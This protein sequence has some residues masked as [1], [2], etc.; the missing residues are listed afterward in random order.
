MASTRPASPPM[1]GN[2]PATKRQRLGNAEASELPSNLTND[3]DLF[4][5]SGPIHDDTF[6]LQDGSC[7][8][9]IEDVLF[10]VRHL[11]HPVY[12]AACL[13]A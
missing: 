12:H 3:G 11:D 13:Y 8:I 10:N 5:D 2:S 1:E 7:I 6:Y 4:V 9:R